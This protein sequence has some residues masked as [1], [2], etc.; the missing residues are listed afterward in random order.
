VGP[1]GAGPT[2]PRRHLLH[3]R[4]ELDIGD[5]P[6]RD[7]GVARPTQPRPTH[8]RRI[9]KWAVR[10]WL[11]RL[12]CTRGLEPLPPDITYSPLRC[13]GFRTLSEVTVAAKSRTCRTRIS[14]RLRNERR[15]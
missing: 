2:G 8:D 3:Q 4:E 6:E 10:R 7:M 14:A 9:G 11:H 5:D 13:K 15:A 1:R 12:P